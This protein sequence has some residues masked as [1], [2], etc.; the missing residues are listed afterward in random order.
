MGRH[1]LHHGNGETVEF[2]DDRAYVKFGADVV[3]ALKSEGKHPWATVTGS[4]GSERSILI[5][6]GG[7]IWTESF[8][9]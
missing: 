9:D 5:V 6:A 1:I 3:K 2:T 4:D 7:P 8:A